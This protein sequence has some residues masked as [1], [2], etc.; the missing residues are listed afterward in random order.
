MY[1][2]VQVIKEFIV[3]KGERLLLVM[4]AFQKDKPS[5]FV[6]TANIY[7]KPQG[8]LVIFKK[9]LQFLEPELT[10]TILS[11]WHYFVYVCVYVCVFVFVC[12]Y[13]LG[14]SKEHSDCKWLG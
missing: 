6:K 7:F 12:M 5:W 9:S 1:V 14:K 10:E 11:L 8:I 3:S 2:K 4:K 13:F